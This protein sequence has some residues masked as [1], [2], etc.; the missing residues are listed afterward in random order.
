MTSMMILDSLALSPMSLSSIRSPGEVGELL[1]S[2]AKRL[3]GIVTSPISYMKMIF[4]HW[5]LHGELMT[6]THGGC[7]QSVIVHHVECEFL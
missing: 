4:T 1:V 5:N 2:V 7:G 6:T 3:S